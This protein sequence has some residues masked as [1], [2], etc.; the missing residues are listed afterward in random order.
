[1]L[2][3]LAEHAVRVI[4]RTRSFFDRQTEPGHALISVSIPAEAPPIPPLRTFDLDYQLGE[5]LDLRL[6]A[7]AA[8]W[9]AKDGLDDDSL[10]CI[11]PQFG[12][13]EHAAWLGLDVHLQDTTCLAVPN[14]HGPADLPGVRARPDCRWFGYMRDGYAHLRRRQN[15]RFLLAVRG[16]MAPMDLANAVRGDDLFTDFLLNPDFAH[17]LLDALVAPTRWYYEQLTAWA[18]DLDGGRVLHYG[19]GWWP[20]GSIGHL[21]NDAA[22]LCGREVYRTFGLPYETRLVEGYAHVLYHVHTQ[23]MHYVPDLATLPNLALLEL[24]HDPQTP[25]PIENLAAMLAATGRAN[26]ML[27]G[28]SD[29]IRTRLAELAPRNVFLLAACQDR[30]DAADLIREVRARTRPL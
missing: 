14:V 2:P 10:P 7:A 18:D 17:D 3:A 19:H 12:I 4:A 16:A 9:A 15:G 20:P 23:K 28:T 24:T 13:A 1:M 26:L 6:A 11:A 27:R 25:A 30:A 8:G 5:W 21:S 29:Q 22:M